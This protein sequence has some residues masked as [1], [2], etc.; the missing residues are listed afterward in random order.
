MQ[1]TGNITGGKL[2]TAFVDVKADLRSLDKGFKKAEKD[3]GLFSKNMQKRMKTV[4]LALTGV[5]VAAGAMFGKAIKTT[6]SFEQSMANVQSVAG[7]S[8]KE[9]QTL[10]TYAREM[11]RE[12]VFSASQ[13]ADAMYFLASAGMDTNQIMGALQGTMN[14]AAATQSDLASTSET[15]AATLSAFGLKANEADRVAN[16]FAATISGSQANMEKLSTSMNYVG[17]IAKSMGMSL[18][19]TTAILGQLYNQGIDAS[20]AGTALRQSITSLLKPTDDAVDVLKK[21]GVTIT[22][23]EGK[24]KPLVNIIGQ[25]E[26]AGLSTAD[27]MTIF[28]QRAG[29]AMLALVSKGSGAIEALTE[30]VT[31]TNKASEMAAIQID[32]FQGAMKLLKS[33]VEDLQISVGVTLLPTLTG[34]VEKITDAVAW[35]N[36]LPVPLKEIGIKAGIAG[37]ALAAVTGPLLLMIG[38]LPKIVAGLSLMKGG[39]AVLPLV[40][41]PVT[42]AIGL[43]TIAIAGAI[44]R[45][46][47]ENKLINQQ[48]DMIYALTVGLNMYESDG[49]DPATAKLVDF[50]ANMKKLEKSLGRQVLETESVRDVLDELHSKLGQVTEATKKTKEATEKLTIEEQAQAMQAVALQERHDVLRGAVESLFGPVIGLGKVWKETGEKAAESY[51]RAE[52][53]R[54]K[55][56]ESLQAGAADYNAALGEVVAD[57]EKTRETILGG[58]VALNEDFKEKDANY[59]ETQ[60]LR[61]KDAADKQLELTSNMNKELTTLRSNQ[62]HQ[63][64]NEMA[65]AHG[66][67]ERATEAHGEKQLE[68]Q[69]KA[70]QKILDQNIAHNA[71]VVEEEGK[72]LSAIEKAT[73]EFQ[74]T[75]LGDID[76]HNRLVDQKYYDL[77][78]AV[79]KRYGEMKAGIEKHGGDVAALE[80]WKND[81]IARLEKEHGE[82]IKTKQTE[83]YDGLI[84]L[85]KTKYGEISTAFSNHLIG[86]DGLIATF[87]SFTEDHKTLYEFW[88][89]DILGKGK[90]FHGTWLTQ[91]ADWLGKIHTEYTDWSTKVTNVITALKDSWS[92]LVSVLK[93]VYDWTK[94][95]GAVEAVSGVAKAITGGATATGGIGGATAGIGTGATLTT[96]ATIAGTA[97]FAAAFGYGAY[98]MITASAENKAEEKRLLAEHA[99]AN[100]RIYEQYQAWVEPEKER[101]AVALDTIRGQYPDTP[102]DLSGKIQS[103]FDKLSTARGELL[104]ARITT[105]DTSSYVERVQAASRSGKRIVSQ[106]EAAIGREP[107]YIWDLFGGKAK[108]AAERRRGFQ[109]GGEVE[110]TGPAYLHA[111]EYVLTSQS[112]DKIEGL[113]E[114]ILNQLYQRDSGGSSLNITVEGSMITDQHSIDNFAVR[115]KDSLRRQG[116]AVT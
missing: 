106:L 5:G 89:N 79:L 50:D 53:A 60:Y 88:Y 10:T 98:K 48:E 72:K 11:G 51:A 3:T 15:T 101:L 6:A 99:E 4:G 59:R 23:D 24:L 30:K 80:K 76:A 114:A 56:Q 75:E 55:F 110:Q 63:E 46:K 47:E 31:G 66:A 19:E 54:G 104:K 95:A 91:T 116:F 29:P 100:K 70:A 34:F 17:P 1:G 32:T 94:K 42:A 27:A 16:V 38:Y 61:A 28:G 77:K 22:D 115:L 81:E 112:S 2:G 36:Q 13:A 18:E 107:T 41:N 43:F 69:A 12:S 73:L 67:V 82:E 58:M 57:S 45:I 74:A 21:L 44:T 92:M 83:S 96:A 26:S 84:G 64:R 33:A 109:Y 71:K 85:A 93:T 35:T 97:T 103:A 105:Y 25:L 78:E 49:L 111:G 14:L 90:E 37:T 40:L 87:N 86:E 8:A 39:L 62:L 52:E 68:T 108:R 9:L 65:A 20:T 102:M 7:A 113:L